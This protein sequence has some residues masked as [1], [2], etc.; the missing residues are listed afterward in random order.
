VFGGAPRV[1]DQSSTSRGKKKKEEGKFEEEEQKPGD[2]VNPPPFNP[3]SQVFI[4][5]GRDYQ[6]QRADK[7]KALRTFAR[8]GDESLREALARL[9][10]LI[11]ATHGVT[12]QQAVQHWYSILD[13]EL[14]TLVRNEALRLD[15]PPTLRFVFET[16]E[17]IE[18]NL[19]EE[20]AAMGFFK[21]EEKPQEKVKAAKA[22]LSS[23]AVDTSMTC[24]KCGKPGH[25]RKECKQGK[26]DSPQSGGYCS[27]C[28]AK[29]HSK[30]K[31]WKLHPDLKPAGS[32]CAKVGGGEKE[33]NTK[34][35][36]GDKKSWKA[37]FAELEAKMVAMSATTKPHDTPSFHAG[38]GSL[39]DDEEF[40]HF[41]LSGMAITAA[42]LTLEAFAHT[43]SQT[44]APKEVPRGV[45]PSLDPQRG[46]GNK[47]AQLPE[48]FTLGEVVPTSSMVPP[49]RVKVPSAKIAQG[50]AESVEAPGMVSEAVARV[51]QA[52][53]FSAAMVS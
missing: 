24:F 48:S 49:I 27:G 32:K 21:R 10:R 8:G 9:R 52:P 45:S 29:G 7:M 22:S 5:L 46:E 50:G 20:K 31:Y 15:E 35:M 33:K 38:G 3:T 44:A 6:G 37:R 17:Q 42:D 40:E 36:D 43:R 51:Y 39:S 14:K 11:S 34:A 25:L 23:R 53:L 12:E 19:L 18:I 2:V 41:I 28:G 16:S 47:Q 1:V 13:K 26:S 30:A 4:Q